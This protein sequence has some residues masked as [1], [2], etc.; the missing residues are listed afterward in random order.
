MEMGLREWMIVIGGVLILAVLADGV[1]RMLRDR[2]DHIRLARHVRNPLPPDPEEDVLRNPEL[3]SG[4]ARVKPRDEFEMAPLSVEPEDDDDQP[5]VPVLMDTVEP[6]V[7]SGGNTR[8]GRSDEPQYPAQEEL[9]GSLPADDASEDDSDQ[10]SDVIVINVMA[11]GGYTIPGKQLLESLLACDLRFGEMDIFHR[12]T[13]GKKRK[14]L[15][16]V[17]NLVKPGTFDIDRMDDFSTPGISMF[18]PLPG[19]PDPQDA[20]RLMLETAR[21]LAGQLGAEMYDDQHCKLRQQA[22]EHMRER[23]VEFERKRL[24]RS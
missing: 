21:A 19:P 1:R 22:L 8:A 23:I 6:P 12:Y 18:M 2:K 9:F 11:E 3:P 13:R 20:F 15:F 14:T 17:A 7:N 5:G 24:A 10:V 4:R 16:S